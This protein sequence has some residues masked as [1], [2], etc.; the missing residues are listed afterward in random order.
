MGADLCWGKFK[1]VKSKRRGSSRSSP[2]EMAE[3]LKAHAWKACVPQG[4]V[5]SNP[6]L[7]AISFRINNLIHLRH[8]A[9]R[10]KHRLRLCGLDNRTRPTINV[11]FGTVRRVV[12]VRPMPSGVFRTGDASPDFS[13]LG[14]TQTLPIRVHRFPPYG[15]AVGTLLSLTG[16]GAASICLTLCLRPKW[17]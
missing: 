3:W 6:T 1:M 15:Q 11:A 17:I 12:R 5:G 4:T 10:F 14:F 16:I 9:K 8:A 7:S 13:A 2:G